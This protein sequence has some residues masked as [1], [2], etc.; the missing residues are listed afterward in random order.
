[1]IS[2]KLDLLVYWY[3]RSLLKPIDRQILKRILRQGLSYPGDVIM[4]LGISQHL[5]LRKILGLKDKGYIIKEEDSNRIRINP[6]RRKEVKVM[7]STD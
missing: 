5:G 3:R 4:S 1:M 6:D 2:K 7:T